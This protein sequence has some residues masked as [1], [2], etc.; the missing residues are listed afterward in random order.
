MK[1]GDLVTIRKLNITYRV[2]I[3]SVDIYDRISTEVYAKQKKR[4]EHGEIGVL[5][6]GINTVDEMVQ[7]LHNGQIGWVDEEY[8]ATIN[9]NFS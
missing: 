9:E 6:E 7:V 5:L 4:W 8:L 1:P 2:P 3:T